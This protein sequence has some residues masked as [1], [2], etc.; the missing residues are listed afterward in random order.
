MAKRFIG[1]ELVSSV[2]P[3]GSIQAFAGADEPE[4][5]IFC[6]GGELEIALY[7]GL[8]AAIGTTWNNAINPTS[9]TAHPNPPAGYFRLPDFRG[10]FLRGAGNPSQGDNTALAGY[11]VDKTAKNGLTAT[12]ASSSISGSLINTSANFGSGTGS[13]TAFNCQ[14]SSVNNGSAS[15]VLRASLSGTAAAQ[16]ITVG[17]GDSETRPLNQGV[18]YIIKY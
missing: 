4:G 13:V 5:W 17:N 2:A 18:N 16:T 8:Y 1:G 15:V 11:Q 12:A 3:A 14:R 7:P 10:A 9:G 6:T